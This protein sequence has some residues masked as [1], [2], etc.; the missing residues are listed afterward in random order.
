MTIAN[1]CMLVKL[2]ISAWTATKL[3]K[4]E[5]NK[6]MR[7]NGV[8]SSSNKNPVRV[9]KDIM[10]GGTVVKN[11][12]DY[13]AR[14]RLDYNKMTLPFEDNGW[15]ILP[16]AMYFEFIDF[17]NEREAGFTDLV[18][19]LETQYGSMVRASME[20]LSNLQ[21]HA[22]YTDIE[23]VLDKYSFNLSK[24]PMPD[25][26]HFIVDGM[27]DELERV[28]AQMD[29]ERDAQVANAVAEGGERVFTMLESMSA[30]LDNSDP[31]AKKRF[32]DNWLSSAQHLC[33]QAEK[34]NLTGNSRLKSVTDRFQ[35]AIR[36][37]NVDSLKHSPVAR[38]EMKDQLDSILKDFL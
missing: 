32:H 30:K 33:E 2:N 31:E 35:N 8:H 23:D 25:S 34:W 10:A 13:A 28:K 14:C 19:Q 1:R 36:G 24:R 18:R 6:V 11:I 3:D 9:Y 22:D 16:T 7:D 21:D 15:R 38:A 12:K 5:S 27:G 4:S 17:V 20:M 26:G 37:Y 29:A